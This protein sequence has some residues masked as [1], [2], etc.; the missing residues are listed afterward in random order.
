MPSK[1]LSNRALRELLA[2]A[3]PDERMR[4]TKILDEDQ[5]VP[6]SSEKI[7]EEICVAGGHSVVN[8]LRGQG[9]GYLDILDDVASKLEIQ[10]RM[11]Y[12]G[13]DGGNSLFEIDQVDQLKV[14]EAEGL[15]RGLDYAAMVEEKI[16]LKVLEMAYANMSAEERKEFDRQVADVAKDFDADYSGKLAG[17]SGLVIL[18]NLGGFATYTFLTTTMSAVSFGTLS[19]GAYTT[20]TTWMSYFLGPPGWAAIGAFGLFALGKPK[21]KKLIPLVAGV[22]TIRQ[23]IKYEGRGES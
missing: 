4:L 6:F 5:K 17:A 9:T 13:G 8:V 14:P 12:Y 7:Q 2:E 19:F 3:T 22:G 11:P 20:A 16:I 18:G 21:M 10:G 15:K 1:F 23:R